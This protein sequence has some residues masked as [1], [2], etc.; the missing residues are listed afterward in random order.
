[1][2]RHN[3]GMNGVSICLS[4]I[5]TRIESKLMN[6]GSYSFHHWVAQGL[7]FDTKFHTI[8]QENTPSE[9]F[10]RSGT[11]NMQIFDQQVGNDRQ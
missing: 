10:R 8:G 7:F 1:M 9:V 3:V 11:A 6:L 5:L 4:V 2:H